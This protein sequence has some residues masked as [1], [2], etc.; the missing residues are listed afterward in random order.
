MHFS[1]F[2]TREKPESDNRRVT[3][4]LS[5]PRGQAVNSVFASDTYMGT[6]FLLTYPS[7]DDITTKVISLGQGSK[8]YK[9]NISRAFRHINMDPSDYNKLGLKWGLF[10]FD[11]GLP[12]GFRHGSTIFQRVS[13]VVQ[14]IMRQK[15]HSIINYIDDYISYGLPS[16]IK[17]S[18]SDLCDLLAQLG[19]AISIK[20]LV[21]PATMVTCL[22]VTIDTI[23]ATISVPPQ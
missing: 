4:D 2:I 6:Q 16:N 8:L 9:L 23:N 12:F 7:V 3:V 18:F 15:G 5:W 21:P 19:F 11:T 17:K 14:F 10:F 22:V 20:K 1:P 13:D